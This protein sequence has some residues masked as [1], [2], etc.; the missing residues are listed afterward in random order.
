[1]ESA[2]IVTR[3]IGIGKK[4]ED[5]SHAVIAEYTSPLADVYGIIHATP[6]IDERFA[7]QET[8]LK[9]IKKTLDIMNNTM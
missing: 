8:L 4:S 5:G 3:I 1:M 2:K 9:H 6:V 7:D